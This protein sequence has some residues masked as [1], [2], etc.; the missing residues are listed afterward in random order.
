MNNSN[1]ASESALSSGLPLRWRKDRA[2]AVSPDGAEVWLF[3][4][5][6]PTRLGGRNAGPLAAAVDGK[7]TL[8]G[9]I[10]HAAAAGM[11]QADADRI[12][13]RWRDS[14]HLVSGR[15]DPDLCAVR[16]IDRTAD[17][18]GGQGESFVPVAQ[19]FAAALRLADIAVIDETAAGVAEPA[20]ILTLIV[21]DDLLE[22]AGSVAGVDGAV[23]VAQLRGERPMVS[24]LLC[25]EGSCP[26]CLDER[27]RLRRTPDLIAS[28][29]VGRNYPPP[30]PTLHSLALPIVAGVAACMAR[31]CRAGNAA[32][33]LHRRHLAVIE[34][35]TGRVEYHR[36]FPVAGC[37]VCDPGGKTV[38]DS[39]LTHPAR[40]GTAAGAADLTGHN[41]QSRGG[42]GFRVVDPDV[43]WERYSPLISDAVGLVPSVTPTGPCEMRTFSAGSNIAASD[44]LVMFRSRL[45]SS[46][47]GKGLT[48][49]AA[50]TGALAEALERDS[51]RA[52]GNEPYRRARMA[53]LDDPLHPNDI[54]LFSQ[55]QLRLSEQLRALEI[56]EPGDARGFHQV[57]RL[58]NTDAEHDWSR[59][60]NI[61]T[62]NL[63]WL[64]SSLLWFNWPNRP[65]GYPSG[66]SNGAAAG[67]TVEEALLQGVFELVERDSVALWWYPRCRRPAM[68]LAAWNDPRIEAALAPQR[69]LGSRVWVLDVTTDL[70]IPA[71][72]AV[73]TGVGPL[74]HIP[75]LGF[76]A[77]LDPLIAVVRALTEL[78]QMQAPLLTFDPA[79]P[80]EFPG[81]AERLWFDQVTPESEPWLM[82]HGMVTPA[83]S[84]VYGRIEEALDDAVGRIAARGIDVLWADCTR[85]DIGL[86]VVK[87][88]A[89][90]LR[91]FW[92]RFAPGRLY[93]VPPAIGWCEPGY[94]E[95]D[96]NPWAMIL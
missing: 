52:R 67:N 50:R 86:P 9:I 45:R 89:P 21:V 73:G 74:P 31:S 46:S 26:F 65:P 69:A 93:D 70:G 60:A 64:P 38:M 83:P 2:V 90:G 87:T 18:S 91:H 8:D 39:H 56:A 62:G 49:T 88:W 66:S 77:H 20:P 32:A 85:P 57:P 3:G 72:V 43:T 54:Q 12:A 94:G 7:R 16:L 81:A 4:G 35:I 27:L 96:L 51:L 42:G 19:R 82:P 23:V 34:P 44:D 61:R 40:G 10:A 17:L 75:L 53:D 15:H 22:A 63:R 14:G 68:D 58:F 30:S 11:N 55:R 71:A 48:L 24:P 47:G 13:R 80:I 25:P 28:I 78:A 1:A 92:N 6:G 59:V 79:L 5:A 76:G 29:R 95:D 33:E 37:P 84:P 36:L 41:L